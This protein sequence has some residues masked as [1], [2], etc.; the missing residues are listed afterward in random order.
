MFYS[1]FHKPEKQ[2][3]KHFHSVLRSTGTL[4]LSMTILLPAENDQYEPL[5]LS[6]DV[7]I[8]KNMLKLGEVISFLNMN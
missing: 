8:Y 4:F 2:N 7:N 5:W 1:F 3:M 6:K